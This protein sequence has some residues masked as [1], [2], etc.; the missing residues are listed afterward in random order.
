MVIEL[1]GVEFWSEIISMISDQNCMTQGSIATLLHP[2]LKIRIHFG[3]SVLL[4]HSHW[5]RK[6]CDLEKKSEICE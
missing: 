4:F 3:C 5:L 1:T 2:F 6:R